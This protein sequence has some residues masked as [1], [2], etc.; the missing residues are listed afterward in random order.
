MHL[1]RLGAEV[2]AA[3]VD[4]AGG[5]ETERRGLGAV[6]FVRLDLTDTDD[7]ADVVA[8]CAPTIVVNNA[9]GGAHAPWRYP[10]ATAEQWVSTLTVNLVAPM[11]I[12]QLA[13]PA[14]QA[15]GEGAV[16]NIA[17]SAARGSQAHTWPEY[18]TAKAGLVR[19]TTS[20][21]DF[22]EHVRVNC[23]IPDWIATERLSDADRLVE[24]PP[25]PLDLIGEQVERLITDDSLSG[26]AVVLDRG[27]APQLLD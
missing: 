14:M 15:A 25:I 18:A 1:A 19:F 9:G 8:H 2:V 5:R 12:T 26:R 27:A 4:V 6:E 20:L 17:S 7:I 21:R 23:L 16:V 22:D 10:Q 3:D 13:L 24:P 11:R